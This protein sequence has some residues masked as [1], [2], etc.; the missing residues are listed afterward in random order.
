MRADGASA[1]SA[2]T[3]TRTGRSAGPGD[4]SAT[5]RR[6]RMTGFDWIG[7]TR[8]VR[9]GVDEETAGGFVVVRGSRH[10]GTR[11]EEAHVGEGGLRPGLRR[12]ER[13]RSLVGALGALEA[14]VVEQRVP[15]IQERRRV[16]RADRG[17][18]LEAA[19]PLGGLVP[20]AMDRSTLDDRAPVGPS[21][22]QRQRVLL[23]AEGAEQARS[24]D[25]ECSL[26]VAH[27]RL[28]LD[29]DCVGGLQVCRGAPGLRQAHDRG[30]ERP[31]VDALCVSR[32]RDPID[33]PGDEGCLGGERRGAKEA[34]EGL[35]GAVEAGERARARREET[36][37]GP[38][39]LERQRLQWALGRRDRLVEQRDVRGVKRAQRRR[40][41][42]LL[43]REPMVLHRQRGAGGVRVVL[44]GRVLYEGA[45]R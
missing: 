1:R 28:D 25:D 12:L 21:C 14:R 18:L 13:Q 35:A 33:A 37:E 39:G 29:C 24:C 32:V 16:V 5:D 43:E 19:D 31:R 41:R 8:D 34:I 45:L 27:A 30:R 23:P 3:R 15:E 9:A 22:H 4:V 7:E 42:R 38:L 20:L 11:G 40:G 26:A 17:G 2:R 44:V 10:G 6:T 36:E